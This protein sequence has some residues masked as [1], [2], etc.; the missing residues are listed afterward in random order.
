[1]TQ[2]YAVVMLTRNYTRQ[3]FYKARSCQTHKRIRIITKL[4]KEERNHAVDIVAGPRK[5][6]HNQCPV[7]LCTVAEP[8]LPT[9]DRTAVPRDIS[10]TIAT[11]K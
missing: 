6:R 2:P 7:A 10:T 11:I 1:M 9:T 3:Q 5:W 8:E 4:Q